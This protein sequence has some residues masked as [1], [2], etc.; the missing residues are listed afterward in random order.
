MP[1]P[2]PSIDR[3][4][5]VTTS[6]GPAATRMPTVP[7]ARTEANVPLPSMVSALVTVRAPKPPGSVTSISPPAAVLE[8]APANVLHGAVRLHGLASSPNPETQVRIADMDC[9]S[10]VVVAGATP[11]RHPAG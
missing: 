5:S 10:E 8:T 2:P 7:E 1:V 11:A 4:R 3:L 9:P 6:P